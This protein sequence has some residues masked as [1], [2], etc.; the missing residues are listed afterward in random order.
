MDRQVPI[1]SG[2]R[3]DGRIDEGTAELAADV[4][5]RRIAFANIVLVG[6][7][8]AGDGRWVLVDAGPPGAAA[9]IERAAAERFGEEARPAAIVLTHAH[10]DHTGSLEELLRRWNVPLYAHPLE[11]PWL[12][13]RAAHPALDP[14]AGEATMARLAPQLPGAPLDV[15]RWLHALPDDGSIP[16]M[17]GWRWLHTPGHTP[18]HV[19]FWRSADRT[20]LAGD[21]FATTSAESA[22]AESAYAPPARAVLHGPA[23]F[24]TRDWEQAR[25]SVERLSVLEPERVVTG[26]GPAMR[27]SPMRAALH[28]L[29]REFERRARDARRAAPGEGTAR[30]RTS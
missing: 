30:D 17:P 11:L 6:A 5:W 29:A 10:F 26:H 3:A 22:Y 14:S 2:A 12:G 7:P 8:G 20:L 16:G 9:T 15:S 19:S 4:A 28:T 13:G 23:S 25:R 1:D 27:G 21:A 18:G 24:L